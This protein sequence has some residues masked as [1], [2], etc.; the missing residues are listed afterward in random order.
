MK[1]SEVFEGAALEVLKPD[2][3][4]QMVAGAYHHPTGP[5]CAQGAV[6][7]VIDQTPLLREE[8]SNQKYMAEH[9]SLSRQVPSYF[10]FGPLE[11]AGDLMMNKT[12][13]RPTRQWGNGVR[14]ITGMQYNDMPGRTAEEVAGYLYA[15]AAEHRAREA[16]DEENPS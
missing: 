1:L 9:G 2:G 4:C 6:A 3:W 5:V 10:W 14:R 12:T 16:Y 13:H 8:L 15:C 7:R 11:L